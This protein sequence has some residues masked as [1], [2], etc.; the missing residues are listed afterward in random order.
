MSAVITTV[1]PFVIQEVL[2]Q[3]LE[4]IGAEPVLITTE[5][6]GQYLHRKTIQSQD[7][8]TNRSDY[9]GPQYFRCVN[10]VW[11]LL[12]DSSQMQIRVTQKQYQDVSAFLSELGG[13]Y[14]QQ[15]VLY[16]ERLAEQERQRIEAER[17]ARVEATRLSVIEKA[18]KQ[19]YSV[20]EVSNNGKIQLVLTRSM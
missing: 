18:R 4:I 17:Q 11:G 9:Y 7:I 1:T 3:A 2:L 20:K 19:G 6:Q 12:H 13:V 8:V 10:G 5:N 16:Q 14:E 15:Y